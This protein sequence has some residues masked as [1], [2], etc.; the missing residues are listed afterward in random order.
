M[1]II[2]YADTSGQRHYAEIRDGA[3][4]RLNGSFPSFAPTEETVEPNKLL[5][6][7]EPPAVYCIGLNYKAHAEEQGAK[8]PQYPVVFMK[9]PT[10]V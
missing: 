8:L 7:V 2:R 4:F 10:A 1:K 5:A 6:P 9:A 3:Y